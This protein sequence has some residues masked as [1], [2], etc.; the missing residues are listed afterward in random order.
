MRN[1]V[2]S[3]QLYLTIQQPDQV[4]IDIKLY[5][6]WGAQRIGIVQLGN[7]NFRIESFAPPTSYIDLQ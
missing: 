1:I 4:D 6:M 7:C 3:M 2:V 5:S